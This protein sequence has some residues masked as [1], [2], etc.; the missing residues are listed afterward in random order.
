MP[1]QKLNQK[2]N[3]NAGIAVVQPIEEV[4]WKCLM[5][6][7]DFYTLFLKRSSEGKETQHKELIYPTL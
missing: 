1:F 4:W 7:M 6:R 2:A 3:F 5:T